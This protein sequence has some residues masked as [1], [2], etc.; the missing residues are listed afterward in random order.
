VIDN[1]TKCGFDDDDYSGQKRFVE[2]LSDFA[3]I[4]ETHVV[5][6]AHMSKGENEDHPAGKMRVKGSGGITDMADTVIEVWRNK[7]RE[8]AILALTQYG[9]PIPENLGT[10]DTYLNVLKQR[11]TGLE[12][13][14]AL[15]FNVDTTQ[16][17]SA[18][19][20]TPR[21]LLDIPTRAVA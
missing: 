11:A 12:P 9:T 19:D 2:A 15:W 10:A 8:R 6:V 7:P 21:P 13:S 18:P 17:L 1:L 3:R 20:F 16:F 14:I 5:I 4:E